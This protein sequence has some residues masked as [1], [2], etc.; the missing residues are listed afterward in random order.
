[1]LKYLKKKKDKLK[2]TENY[3]QVDLAVYRWIQMEE[4]VEW[5]RMTFW[6]STE[7]EVDL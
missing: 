7:I 3:K 1:M 2:I 5:Q 6:F 4:A